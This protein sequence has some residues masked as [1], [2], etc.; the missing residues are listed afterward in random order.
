VNKAF[1]DHWSFMLGEIAMYALVVLILTGTYLT[2]FFNDSQRE[3]VY[4]GAYKPLDGVRMSEAYESVVHLSFDVRAG[5]VMRQIHHW[6]ALVFLAAI[7]AHLCRIFF[8]GAFRRPRELN[9]IVGVTLL[10]LRA[11]RTA[12]RGY[13]LPDDLLSGTGLRV[14]NA[15][16]LSIPIV[17]PH[18]AF[19]AFDGECPRHRD[20]LAALHPPRVDHPGR[21]RRAAERAPRDPSGVR[22]TRSSAA[23]ASASATSW[24]RGLWPTYAA[25]SIGLF[26]IVAGVPLGA[27][28]TRADQPHLALRTVRPRRGEHRG[29]ARLVSRLDRGRDPAVSALVSAH[30]ALP[31]S[32]RCSG[33]RSRSPRS[34]SRCSTRGRSSKAV[35][36]AT[37]TSTIS[38]IGRAT[39]RC[40][41]AIG[42]GVLTFYVVMLVAGAQDLFAQWFNL[43]IIAVTRRCRCSCSRCR[44]RTAIFTWRVCRDLAAT[45]PRPGHDD[46]FRA[47]SQPGR[48]RQPWRSRPSASGRDDSGPRRLRVARG[49]REKVT[50]RAPETRWY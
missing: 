3:V 9:W 41:P 4:H 2:F 28:W 34:R 6:A 8:T 21:D 35:S 40:A 10:L 12:S 50:E 36:R 22:S 33:R 16:M 49:L 31:A 7:V 27:G 42:V 13:S 18:L 30:R 45:H 47:R 26:A 15:F 19:F 48:P 37:A 14:A 17:G 23:P 25:K 24:A 32:P 1:P 11:W 46:P 5:L 38:L 29:A 44:S 39:G 20:H 43:S